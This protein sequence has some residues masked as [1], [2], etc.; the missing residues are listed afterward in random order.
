MR[1]VVVT[2]LGITSSIGNNAEEVADSLKAGRSGIVFADEYAK[3]NFRSQVHGTVKIDL[4]AAIDRR[5]KRF[6]GDGAAYAYLAMEQAIADSGLEAGDIIN[7]RTG[8]IVGSG[9]ASTRNLVAS[10]DITREKG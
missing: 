8:L 2:G 1:R 6:M 10:A 4:E 7:P 9:G 3:L 5:Q